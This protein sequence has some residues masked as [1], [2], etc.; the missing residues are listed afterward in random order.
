MRRATELAEQFGCEEI[1]FIFKYGSM[2]IELA[3]TIFRLGW[4]SV[5]DVS[6]AR[7]RGT[8]PQ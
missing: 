1:M 4:R 6:R 3:E 8:L 7:C 5:A 2:P